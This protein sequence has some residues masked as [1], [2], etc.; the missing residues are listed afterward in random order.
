MGY[1]KKNDICQASVRSELDVWMDGESSGLVSEA[2]YFCNPHP[3]DDGWVS[4]D[5]GAF[6]PSIV[7]VQTDVSLPTRL[8]VQLRLTSAEVA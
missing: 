8:E 4:S 2:C 6:T 1:I 3:I 7:G 5:C